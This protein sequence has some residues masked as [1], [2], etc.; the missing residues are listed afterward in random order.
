MINL[1][2]Q[3]TFELEASN[4]LEPEVGDVTSLMIRA[5]CIVVCLGPDVV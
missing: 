1:S 4:L 3:V 2:P 5:L